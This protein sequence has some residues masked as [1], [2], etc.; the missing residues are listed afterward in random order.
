MT[1]YSRQVERDNMEGFLADALVGIGKPL[2]HV[3]DHIPS[4]YKYDGNH[5]H[6]TLAI[7]SDGSLPREEDD[8]IA[9]EITFNFVLIVSVLYS[10]DADSW[11]E[12]NS[13]DRL[14]EVDMIITNTFVENSDHLVKE[15]YRGESNVDIVGEEG[16]NSYWVEIIPVRVIIYSCT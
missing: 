7:G 2:Q 14:D 16:G 15:Y 3:F 5:L 11:T 9:P 13:Q 6:F 12:E 4:E 1:V 10:S 8:G